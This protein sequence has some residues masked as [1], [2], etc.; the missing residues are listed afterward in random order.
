MKKTIVGKNVLGAILALAVISPASYAVPSEND[1]AQVTALYQNAQ[2]QEAIEFCDKK[3][4]AGK[5]LAQWHE[6]LAK[7]CGPGRE[8]P[9]RGER[10]IRKALQLAPADENIIATACLMLANSSSDMNVLLPK[11][12]A[13]IKAHPRNA[14]LHAALGAY[15]D[16]M[17]DPL[18]DQEISAA[19]KLAPLDYDVNL[20]AAEHYAKLQKPDEV[21]KA[22][23]RLVQGHP[24]SAVAYA[25][26]GAYRRDSYRFAEASADLH[27]A[28]E[29]NPKYEYAYSMLAKS[30]KRSKNLPEAIK[31][32]TGMMNSSGPSANLLG[33]RANCYANTNQPEKAI[34]D[35]DQAIEIYGKGSKFLVQKTPDSLDK[36]QRLDYNKYWLERA[37][38]REKLGQLDQSITELTYYIAGAT[39]PESAYEIRQRLYRKKGQYEKALVDLNYLIKKDAFVGERYTSRAD[40]YTKLGRTAEAKQ[41]LKH[42]EN[43]EATGSP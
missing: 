2:K 23:T 25:S 26:R 6:M 20:E 8:G 38:C 30:L 36:D 15:Y 9:G 22:Y 5:D 16:A 17:H 19:L 43:I 12:Q 14:R 7:A 35:Y 33:R 1:L 39:Y 24:K 4:A 27:K 11:L 42:A 28:V 3:I 40:V 41:D 18:A 32:Y 34:K 31:V 13:A 37:E 10:E 29:L 21:D